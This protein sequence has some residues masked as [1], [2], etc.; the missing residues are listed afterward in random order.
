MLL[1]IVHAVLPIGSASLLRLD[2]ISF[3]GFLAC[4]LVWRKCPGIMTRLVVTDSIP[5]HSLRNL[6][7]GTSMGM[8][9]WKSAPASICFHGTP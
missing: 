1:S 5:F 6:G 9:G 7:I 2:E 3:T 4:F 8:L